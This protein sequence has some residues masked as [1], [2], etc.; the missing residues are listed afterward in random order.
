[1]S[2]RVQATCVLKLPCLGK[3]K[4]PVVGIFST[5]DDGNSLS[6]RNVFDKLKVMDSVENSSYVY[7]NICNDSG[8]WM[9]NI[10]CIFVDYSFEFLQILVGLS[11]S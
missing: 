9:L 11:V 5:P 2:L 4:D 1:M 10:V 3:Q 7:F 8:H 6:F